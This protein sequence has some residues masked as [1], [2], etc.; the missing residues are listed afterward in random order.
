MLQNI[1]G[2]HCHDVSCYIQE[3]HWCQEEASDRICAD[4]GLNGG[5]IPT[6]QMVLLYDVNVLTQIK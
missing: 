2:H 1:V 3:R 5:T 4:K 6:H